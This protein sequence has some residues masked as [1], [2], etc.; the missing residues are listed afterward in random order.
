[1]DFFTVP[2]IPNVTTILSSIKEN[3]VQKKVSNEKSVLTEKGWK[4]EKKNHEYYFPNFL[5]FWRIFFIGSYSGVAVC[6]H[7]A[8]VAVALADGRVAVVV[9]QNSFFHDSAPVLGCF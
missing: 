4:T 7:G 2:F 5:T 8:V 9:A 1:M 6:V 3:N